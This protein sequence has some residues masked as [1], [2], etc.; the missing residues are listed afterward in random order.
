MSRT[1]VVT[2]IKLSRGF[3]VRGLWAHILSKKHLLIEISAIS[4]STILGAEMIRLSAVEATFKVYWKLTEIFMILIERMFE[5][6]LRVLFCLHLLT[7]G[8]TTTLRV[9]ANCVIGNRTTLPVCQ[10]RF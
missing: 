1:T 9:L 7:G 2:A 8:P 6:S 5:A 3:F 10:I 4:A